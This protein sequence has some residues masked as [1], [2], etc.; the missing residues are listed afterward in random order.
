MI[1][2]VFLGLHASAQDSSAEMSSKMLPKAYP[3]EKVGV[4]CRQGDRLVMVEYSDL[5]ED[6]AAQRGADGSLRFLA[7][8]PAIHTLGAE[9]VQRIASDPD[10]ALPPHRAE[11][12][13][14]HV[15]LETGEVIE[16]AAPNA[17]KLEKFV[18]D[19]LPLARSSIVLETDRTEEFAPIKNA[20]GIDSVVSS[21]EI[22]TERAARWL[23]RA[24]V[25]VPRTDDG[26]PDCI[27]ELRPER[28]WPE[29]DQPDPPARI[30]RGAAMVI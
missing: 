23:E 22:Q 24:G 15:D 8:S 9:F 5:P 19:A 3:E 13:V 27:L 21:R 12:K 16:P 29:L 6:L 17:V 20:T 7:G 14:S 11:K 18:F 30:E 25:E 10:F 4:F 28:L 26:K 2:P 1:D